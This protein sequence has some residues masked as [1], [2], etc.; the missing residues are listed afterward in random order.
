MLIVATEE[1]G[2]KG[3]KK[4]KR[5]AW[6]TG[7]KCVLDAPGHECRK[8]EQGCE[9]GNTRKGKEEK[10]GSER[11]AEFRLIPSKRIQERWFGRGGTAREGRLF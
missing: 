11:L 3:E 8:K 2:K 6:T 4:L 9:G 1:E 7:L 10:A 5:G